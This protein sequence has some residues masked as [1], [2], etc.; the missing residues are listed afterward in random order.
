ME[1]WSCVPGEDSGGGVELLD[2][3]DR[4]GIVCMERAMWGSATKGDRAGRNGNKGIFV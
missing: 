3:S 4:Q 2:E 1:G